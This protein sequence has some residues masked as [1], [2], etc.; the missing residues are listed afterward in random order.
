M[1][2]IFR[3]LFRPLTKVFFFFWSLFDIGVSTKE[4]IDQNNLPH[5]TDGLP[6]SNFNDK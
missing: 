1:G 3:I 5:G 4:G 6:K 2:I